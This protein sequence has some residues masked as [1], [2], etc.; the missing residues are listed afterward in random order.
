MSVGRNPYTILGLP[1][2]ATQREISAAYR[3]LARQFHP[4]LNPHRDAA[5]RM[6]NINWA[7]GVL[8]D[9]AARQSFDRLQERRSRARRAARTGY[10]W[11][12]GE[13]IPA[14]AHSFNLMGETTDR[15]IV[16]AL[17]AV[18]TLA[19]SM[20]IGLEFVNWGAPLALAIGCWIAAVPNRRM[21]SQHGLAIG[22]LIGLFAA[23][24][25]SLSLPDQGGNGNLVTGFLCCTPFTVLV[26]GS[27]G[28]MVG[29]LAG[30]IRQ[31]GRL[32]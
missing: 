11:A 29:S 5:R 32:A 16:G 31:A 9:P 20:L 27:L 15:A 8:G 25:F 2:F 12:S 30:W 13:A 23:A 18:A 1:S 6:Q 26:G 17:V 3:R 4:D 24:G 10:S 21:S 19:I 28:A 22:A 14:A 7:Y